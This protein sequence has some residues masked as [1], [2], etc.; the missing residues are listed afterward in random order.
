M[1]ASDCSRQHDVIEAILAGGWPGSADADL[2]DH[3]SGCVVCGAAAELAAMLGAERAAACTE[4][5]IAPSGAVW[6]RAQMRARQQATRA[7]TWPIAA[8]VGVLV[9]CTAGFGIAVAP[10]LFDWLRESVPA[11]ASVLPALRFPSLPAPV[12][13]PADSWLPV[14]IQ[15]AVWIGLVACVVL[16][17]AAIYLIFADGRDRCAGHQ[18]PLWR[19]HGGAAGTG[20][21]L[22]QIRRCAKTEIRRL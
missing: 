16:T 6:W 7:A 14:S 4:A 9:A 13:P 11:V 1:N 5:R 2:R 20:R 8:A 19:A 22:P 17:P 18:P 15:T 3:V 21:V 10:A 12:A